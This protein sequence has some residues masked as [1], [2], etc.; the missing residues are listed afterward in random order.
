[1][2]IANISMRKTGASEG[3]IGD[4]IIETGAS[5]DTY[6]VVLEFEQVEVFTGGVCI[7]SEQAWKDN[8]FRVASKIAFASFV[9]G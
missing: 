4:I 2:N 9:D 6:R 8:A 3:H 5:V 1:M 7:G